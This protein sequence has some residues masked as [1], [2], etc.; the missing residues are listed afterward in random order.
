MYEQ[1]G[2]VL[3][4]SLGLLWLVVGLNQLLTPEIL[5][6]DDAQHITGMSLSELEALSP[7]ATELIYWLYRG[8]GNLKT[9]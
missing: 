3:Y 2:W 4:L 9:S 7:E 8:M 6:E 5:L 1:Y